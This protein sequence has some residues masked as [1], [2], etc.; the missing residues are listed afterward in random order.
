MRFVIQSS[1]YVVIVAILLHAALAIPLPGPPGKP[2]L[3]EDK[4]LAVME[5]FHKGKAAWHEQNAKYFDADKWHKARK[6]MDEP[7]CTYKSDKFY[8]AAAKAQQREED[9][10]EHQQKHQKL[11]E[12]CK[13]KRK[14]KL[15]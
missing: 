1:I 12:E 3:L 2:G 13:E 6:A 10:K 11:Q 7:P 15:A 14:G 4:G 9:S 8:R 5:Q